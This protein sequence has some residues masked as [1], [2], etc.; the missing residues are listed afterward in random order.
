MD[1][2]GRRRRESES[3]ADF[4]Q[5]MGAAWA[6][7]RSGVQPW[8]RPIREGRWTD[9]DGTEWRLRGR[10]EQPP[11]AVLRRLRKRPG[12]RVLYAYGPRPTE[13]SGEQRDALLERV[14]RYFAGEAPPHSVFW[15]AE[16]RDDDHH[17]ML[18]IEEAC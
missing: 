17:A 11:R 3:F 12:C 13:V 4:V 16:F 9:E 18:V 2:M 14:E 1:A 7:E 8:P 15:L 5:E 10:G 6:V